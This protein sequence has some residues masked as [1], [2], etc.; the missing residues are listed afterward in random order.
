MPEKVSASL[1]AQGSPFRGSSLPQHPFVPNPLYAH[2]I[3]AGSFATTAEAPSMQIRP[4]VPQNKSINREHASS[5]PPRSE[6]FADHSF[7]EQPSRPELTEGDRKE[8]VMPERGSF[9]A[10]VADRAS[11]PHTLRSA[12]ASRST[13]TRQSPIVSRTHN[14]VRNHQLGHKE[15]TLTMRPTEGNERFALLMSKRSRSPELPSGRFISPMLPLQH[16]PLAAEMLEYETRLQNLSRAS[17]A[18]RAAPS[19][20]VRNSANEMNIYSTLARSYNSESFSGFSSKSLGGDRL[21]STLSRSYAPSNTGNPF[22]MSM[23]SNKERSVNTL[24]RSME[25]GLYRSNAQSE[26]RGGVSAAPPLW[27]QY[28]YT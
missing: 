14:S 19:R 13:R 7:G 26:R 4:V 6:E 9:L 11:S 10:P 15:P 1:E 2:L 8:P 24:G 12:S 3:P 17:A 27:A 16:V 5:S 20:G 28:K 23:G 18:S 21:G 25:S 22:A